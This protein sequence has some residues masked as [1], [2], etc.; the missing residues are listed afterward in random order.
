M[1]SISK[2]GFILILLVFITGCYH[3][4]PEEIASMVSKQPSINSW[5]NVELTNILSQEKFKISDFTG[6]P[7]LLESFAVWCPTCTRQQKEIKKLHEEIGNEVISISLDTD[8]NEDTSQVLTHT[9][10]NNFDWIY[11]ISPLRSQ[12]L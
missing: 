7:I 5:K 4:S 2:L 9:Q 11:S 8:P 12:N 10:E 1:K 6:T 3:T